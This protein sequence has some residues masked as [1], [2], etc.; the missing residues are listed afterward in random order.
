MHNPTGLAI[1]PKIGVLC[2]IETGRDRPR[3]RPFPSA[4][5]EPPANPSRPPSQPPRG[6][7]VDSHRANEA[8]ELTAYKGGRGAQRPAGREST[9]TEQTKRQS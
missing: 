8:P 6:P 7:R 4:F 2:T 9:A 3:S 5:T 1:R